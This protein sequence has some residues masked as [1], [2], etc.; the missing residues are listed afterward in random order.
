MLVDI[1]QIE[2]FTLI[3]IRITAA[4]AVLPVF[5]HTAVPAMAKAGLGAA[6]TLLLMPAISGAVPASSGTIVDFFLLA[7]RET[8]CGVLLGFV[9]QCLFWAVDVAGQLIGFQAGFSMASA[10]DPA[11]EQQTTVVAQ[12][13]NMTALLIFITLN[14]HH[15]MLRAISDSLHAV[16]I[17]QL[18]IDAR[19]QVWT[20]M[21]ARQILADGIRLAAPIMVTLLLTDVGL[22]ILTR[23]APALHIFVIGFPLKVAI[24]LLM[25]AIT[26]QVVASI[27]TFEFTSFARGL[28]EI[29]KLLKAP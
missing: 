1:A 4:L 22:G 28:P 14:G 27:F 9:G 2:V 6:L 10:I 25:M 11:T 29:L 5:S 19:F 13:Y 23:I 15:V 20:V 24:T 3:F 26:L 8:A 17:G 18:A 16:P 21:M 12:F 7:I